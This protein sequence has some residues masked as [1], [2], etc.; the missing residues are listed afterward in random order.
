MPSSHQ[1]AAAAERKRLRDRV[2]Q[3]N[4]RM[5]R[6][7]YVQSLEQQ[8]KICHELHGTQDRESLLRVI[9]ELRAENATLR[10]RQHRLQ[11]LF[12]SC[13]DLL[14]QHES[15][16]IEEDASAQPSQALDNLIAMVTAPSD[17]VLQQPSTA[18]GPSQGHDSPTPLTR[19]DQPGVPTISADS[20]QLV[21]GKSTDAPVSADHLFCLQ[22]DTV[23][24]SRNTDASMIEIDGLSET[25]MDDPLGHI[26][27]SSV[28]AERDDT[29]KDIWHARFSMPYT[30]SARLEGA[31]PDFQD[32]CFTQSL[33]FL[34]FGLYNTLDPW[35]TEKGIM[36]LPVW[37]RVPLRNLALSYHLRHSPWDAHIQAVLDAPDEPSPLDLLFGSPHNPLANLLQT[38]VK[39]WYSGDPERLAIGWLTYLHIKWRMQPTF[40]RFLRLPD[41][42]KPTLE[43]TR[44]PHPGCLDMIFWKKLRLNLLKNYNKYDMDAVIRL[45]CRCLKLRW[46]REEEV[47]VPGQADGHVVRP[48]F[49]ERFM[50]EDGWGLRDMFIREYPELFEGLDLQK[51][52]YNVP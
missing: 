28:A 1:D 7:R 30:S 39:K 34:D 42:L 44:L 8:V 6:N 29:A 38:N 36:A 4:L 52:V 5:K 18:P 35:G 17:H 23:A 48:D 3:Q 10:D 26:S 50:C 13:G 2:S 47:L 15:A 11:I 45:Y 46:S 32:D 40:E 49:L 21:Y 43:Q 14:R 27:S 37:A 33:P 19:L 31:S 51:V 22:G 12:N 24:V 20:H 16:V 9:R 25:L 41:C